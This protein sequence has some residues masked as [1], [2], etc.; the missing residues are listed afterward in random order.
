MKLCCKYCGNEFSVY[1]SEYKRSKPKYCSNN[2]FTLDYYGSTKVLINCLNCGKEKT[3]FPADIK[4]G[5][6]KFCSKECSVNYDK[7]QHLVEIKCEGCGKIFNRKSYK[8][9]DKRKFCSHECFLKTSSPLNNYLGINHP[10]WNG[11]NGKVGRK[12]TSET[13]KWRTKI[14]SRDG[15]KCV[16][17]GSSERLEADHK[18]PISVAPHLE[19]E[20][21]NGRTLCHECHKR[22]FTYG[23]KNVLFLRFM[24]KLLKEITKNTPSPDEIIETANK[25]KEDYPELRG[26]NYESL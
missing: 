20:I 24:K 15:Y 9:N 1:P 6:A 3:V 8:I 11:G 25:V 26:D 23:A 2:C 12:R 7:K 22:T 10:L 13:I 21:E 18:W 14:L 16:I 19:F 4:R 5:K 17:C